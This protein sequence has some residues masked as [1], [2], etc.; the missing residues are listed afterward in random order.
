MVLD[1]FAGFMNQ[2]V[3][4]FA[5]PPVPETGFGGI[6]PQTAPVPL[7]GGDRGFPMVNLGP[8]PDQIAECQSWS[9]ADMD[10][11]S[12]RNDRFQR[13]QD[14]YELAP[15]S[16]M[17]RNAANL[18]I[19]NDPK[20]TVNKMTRIIASS[21][22]I[23]DVPVKPGAD[24]VVAQKIENWCYDYMRARNHH[25][26]TG[27]QNPY[28]YDQAFFAVLRGWI[29][30]RT[31]ILPEMGGQAS[32]DPC[33][34]FRHDVVDP[35]L[36]YP[37]RA[38]GAIRRV[39]HSY[40]TTVGD[41]VADPV[42][43]PFLQSGW[44]T[45][46]FRSLAHVTALYWEA[47]DGGW[48]HAIIGGVGPGSALAGNEGLWIKPPTELGYNPWTIVLTGGASYRE[49]PWDDQN[50]TPEV[51]AGILHE[52]AETQKYLNRA[53]TR[54]SELV[55]QQS[56][57]ATIAYTA[58]GVPKAIDLTAGGRNNMQRE[59]RVE[60]PRIGPSVPDFQMYWDIIR[61]S[62]RRSRLPDILYGEFP[63]GQNSGQAAQA[64]LAASRDVF[65]PYT[66]GINTADAA[67]FCK[68]LELYRD[69]GPS[70]PL[71]TR[72]P[73]GNG[74]AEGIR[75]LMGQLSGQMTGRPMSPLGQVTLATLDVWDLNQQG[76]YVDVTRED[77]TPV[78]KVAQVNMALSMVQQEVISRYTARKDY[79]KLRNPQEENSRIIG[80]KAYLDPR[81]IQALLPA[82]L[83]DM[84]EPYLS[85]LYT[86][87]Q[88]GMPGA[89][90]GQEGQQPMDQRNGMD[91]ST[92]P[93]GGGNGDDTTRVGPDEAVFDQMLAQ[94][95]GG[96]SGGAGFGGTPPPFGTTSPITRPQPGGWF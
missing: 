19:L 79:V 70:D 77:V 41:I 22:A 35:A 24:P 3:P 59:D 43:R 82:I 53:A 30:E 94:I 96:A 84:G 76:C 46:D 17:P 2:G 89:V 81:L 16:Q 68:H 47:A 85:Q 91:T 8:G 18:I 60:L 12:L 48:Y 20:T 49:T 64:I 52:S 73:V 15:P 72:L 95:T 55:A 88:T 61:D 78:E 36:V 83:S 63:Q 42:L 40:S 80:E 28:P 54:F 45:Q 4:P 51:G 92:L 23:L 13:D 62:A 87:L 50:F 9:R 67:I 26:A 11:W 10:R 57:P 1:P 31:M 65:W 33:K 56:N 86:M 75:G 29:T 90:P 7:D 58:T 14:L 21:P 39:T 71:S 44:Y 32:Y 38:G 37:Y 66:N 25:W 93:P 27:L 74:M 5:M 34:M 69:F 6:L